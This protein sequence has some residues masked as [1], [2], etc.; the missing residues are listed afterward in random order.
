M[1]IEQHKKCIDPAWN[2]NIPDETDYLNAIVNF[3]DEVIT[4]FTPGE[5]DETIHNG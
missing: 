1:A 4:D 2:G 5:K 3:L